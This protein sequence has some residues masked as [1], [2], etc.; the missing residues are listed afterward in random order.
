MRYTGTKPVA[1]ATMNQPQSSAYMAHHPTDHDA[2]D[3]AEGNE[4]A[5]HHCIE[6]FELFSV[7][8]PPKQKRSRRQINRPSV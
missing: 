1:N 4:Q 6:S 3:D 5:E 7:H 8:R 2:R